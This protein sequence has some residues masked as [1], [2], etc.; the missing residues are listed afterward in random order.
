MRMAFERPELVASVT[1]VSDPWLRRAQMSARRPLGT[2]GAIFR[3]VL[4]PIRG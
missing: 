4:N 1:E 3:N 2:Q